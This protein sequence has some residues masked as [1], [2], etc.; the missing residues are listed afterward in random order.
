MRWRIGHDDVGMRNWGGGWWDGESDRM[1]VEDE[2]GMVKNENGIALIDGS[3]P[4]SHAKCLEIVK[5]KTRDLGCNANE[6]GTHSARSGGATTLAPRVSPFE[7][8]LTGRWADARSLRNYVEVGEERRFQ[9][10]EHLRL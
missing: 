3:I 9:I 5:S 1:M 6:F 2:G 7:L 4:L 10:S 8:M